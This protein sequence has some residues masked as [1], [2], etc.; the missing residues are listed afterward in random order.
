MRVS[1]GSARGTT[2]RG[3][4]DRGTRPTAARLRGSLFDMLSS[5]QADMTEVLDLYAGTGALGIEALSRGEGRCTFVEAEAAAC[6]V[7]HENLRRT[8]MEDRAA[9]VRGRVGTWRPPDGAEYTL[10]LADPPYGVGGAWQAIERS[11]AGALTPHA[12][13]TVEHAARETAPRTLLGRSM[14]RDRRQG[15]GAVAMYC[16]AEG[17][18]AA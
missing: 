10:V 15:D 17:K 2:L 12:I 1:A 13:V 11:V 9:V 14:W 3:P 6:R 8:R 5:S 18:N 16:S 4:R 7:I